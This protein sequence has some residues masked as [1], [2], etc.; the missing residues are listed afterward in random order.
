MQPTRTQSALLLAAI[1]AATFAAYSAT[2]GFEWV[3]D[4]LP[5][6]VTN[7]AVQS[8]EYVPRYFT[9]HVWA[10]IELQQTSYY[11][12][13]FL[14]WLR[15]NHAL[16]GLQPAGWHLTTVLLHLVVTLL[17][18]FFVLR[19]LEGRRAEALLAALVFGLHPVHIESVA[20]VSGVS[21]PLLTVFF[22]A[23]LAAWL[24]G[25]D[26]ERPS[27]LWRG[28]ALVFYALALLSKEPAVVLPALVFLHAAIFP[29]PLPPGSSLWARAREPLLAALPFVL[30]T[31]PYLLAR[32]IVLGGLAHTGVA[33]AW[34][35]VLSTWPSMLWFYAGQLLFPVGLSLYYD[36]PYVEQPGLVNFVLPLAG[37]SVLLAGLWLWQR[38]AD[39]TQVRFASW[40]VI[41]PLLPTLTIQYFRLQDF[42]HDRYLYLP[43]IGLAVLAA[44]ALARLAAGS[45]RRLAALAFAAA[46]LL[47]AAT[48]SQSLHWRNNEALYRR[49]LAVA[50]NNGNVYRDLGTEMIRQ[51]RPLEAIALYEK[52][53]E[54]RPEDWLSRFVLGHTHYHIG[55]YAEAERRFREAIH[56]HERNAS[57]YYFLALTYMATGRL[58]EAEKALRR[59]IEILPR[60]RGY[61]LALGVLYETQGLREEALAAY[62]REA[63]N[64]PADG[65]AQ[66]QL[67]RLEA[68]P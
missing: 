43:S 33:L 59:A 7:P 17:V 56:L 14:L 53:T 36:L 2:P 9:E 52:L 55:Q 16:F 13:L 42:V 54:L 12:P 60:G 11:R 38:R 5:Q 8:W 37:L 27:A 21:D 25:R 34:E 48:W 65:A 26:A 50:P 6:I 47:G 68:Q 46:L 41:L 58:Q 67:Q 44:L 64:H 51:G 45:A 23:S 19:L 62:R 20:W 57:Q 40:L 22:V 32:S 10:H 30:V 4:D 15:L 1:L 63:E 29:P 31:L 18:Y 28:A 35:T 61:H 3:Y 24:K 39:G 49:A 66:Q